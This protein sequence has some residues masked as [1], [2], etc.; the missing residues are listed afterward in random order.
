MK[1]VQKI[2]MVVLALGLL[3]A[4]GCKQPYDLSMQRNR[5]FVMGRLLVGKTCD[6][7]VIW[8]K[9]PDDPAPVTVT[10]DLSEIGGP[11]DQALAASGN[12][13]WRWAGQVSPDT[14]GERLITI[15][16]VDAGAQTKEVSK[17]FR[18]FDTAKAIAIGCGVQGIALKADGTLVEWQKYSDQEP[19]YEPFDEPFYA[20]DNLT[21]V[22]A[23]AAGIYH[24]LALKADGTVI[25]WGQQQEQDLIGDVPE[26]LSDVV[27]IAA[28]GVFNLA[29]KA[30][31]TVVEWG[32]DTASF[33][34]R[35]GLLDAPKDLSDVVEITAGDDFASIS[36]AVARR[37]SSVAEGKTNSA[38]VSSAA[39]A[40]SV[41]DAVELVRAAVASRA[42][43]AK[44]Y[45]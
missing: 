8:R 44:A 36:Q 1:T 25:S 4:V 20:P 23:I 10:V 45:E 22:V 38:D 19:F 18:V 40:S 42:D 14:S 7:R 16:S 17:R 39:G 33:W 34:N 24:N 12:G 32:I 3:A 15:T 21:N 37:Y 41:E 43:R 35:S 31:G 5:I 29:L 6:V 26:G 2:C 11:A 13:T 9:A 27:A 30:D 28:G